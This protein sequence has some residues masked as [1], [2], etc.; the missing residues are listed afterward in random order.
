MPELYVGL[1]S[2]TSLDGID[3]VLVDLEAQT[4]RLG[5]THKEPLPETV[6]GRIE[7]LMAG[8]A[9]LPALGEL[10]VILGELFAAAVLGL[11]EQAQTPAQEIQ[12]IGSHGQTL[13]HQPHG[14][15]PFTLQIGDPNVIAERTGI[16]TVADLRRRDMA[17]GG[18]GAP[19]VPAFHRAML[20]CASEDRVIL[21][22]GGI[23]NITILAADPAQPVMGFDTGPGNT[24]MDGWIR[25][26]LGEAFDRDG[27]W[28]AQGRPHAGLVRRMLRDP[29]FAAPPPKSTGREHFHLEWVDAQL[30]ALSEPVPPQDTQASLLELTA[31]GIAQAISA[32]ILTSPRVLVCGGGAHNRGLMSRLQALM[33]GARVQSTATLGLDPDW[34]E[35]TAFA[36][37][38]QQT[39][40]G[41]PGNLPSVTGARRAVVLGGIYPGAQDGR[42]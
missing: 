23:A 1:M 40:K 10:D 31:Q 3:A 33:P 18:Q 27:R 12:A 15:H 41:A 35:A 19:L 28:A 25:R 39:L 34:V 20:H 6:R 26:H 22:V 30:R 37:L 9:E 2:G 29:Y 5:A 24:L 8:R 14:A 16:T 13:H 7:S 42:P 17:A 4:P 21:N 36:W 32:Q 11:L 38:A